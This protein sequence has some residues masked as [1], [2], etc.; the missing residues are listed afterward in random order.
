[1]NFER[2]RL[3][4]R[5]LAWSFTEA[6]AWLKTFRLLELLDDP[7]FSDDWFLNCSF[8]RDDPSRHDHFASFSH[9]PTDHFEFLHIRTCVR[10][11]RRGGPHSSAC[12]HS[13]RR[14]SFFLSVFTVLCYRLVGC[15]AA[16]EFAHGS[17]ALFLLRSPEIPRRLQFG[18]V[19]NAKI[20]LGVGS[21]AQKLNF[22]FHYDEN[23][24]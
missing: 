1:M 11:I 17:Q 3:P 9:L 4:L 23:P 5:S 22:T 10:R 2:R 13:W 18:L 20:R 24:E 15:S 21:Q 16:D 8:V 7:S 14:H 19:K 12:F 6:V